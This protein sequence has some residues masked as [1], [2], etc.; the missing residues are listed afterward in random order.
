MS[1]RTFTCP[2]GTEWR[3]AGAT[4]SSPYRMELVLERVGSS[5][6]P[7]RCEAEVAEVAELS[8]EELCFLVSNR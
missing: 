2:D 4:R 1:E 7:I 6:R 3:V 8:D 5:H